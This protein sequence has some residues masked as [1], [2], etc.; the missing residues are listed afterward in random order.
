MRLGLTI[1]TL[2]HAIVLAWCVLSFSARRL[3]AV[4]TESLPVDIVSTSEF[5]KM[6]AGVK[7]APKAETPKQL[8]EKVAE[9]KPAP[10]AVAKVTEKQEIKSAASEPAPP[11]VEQPPKPEVKPQKTPDEIA[12]A[13][14]KELVKQPPPKKQPPKFDLSKVENKLALVDKREQRRQ[15]ATGAT[16]NDA[17]SLGT[18]KGNAPSLS[19]SELDALRARLKE[20]WGVPV[21][22]REARDL[23]VEVQFE[24][25]P[26]GSL[27]G[28]PKVV[29]RLSHPAFQVAAEYAVRAVIKGAPYTFLSPAKYDVWKDLVVSFD[30]QQMFGG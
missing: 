21:G 17:P 27:K 5:S 22:V 4:P 2:L 11:K 26:D 15:A 23:L 8:V 13:L 28:E 25:N 3:D 9:E 12:E 19:Q 16:L 30:P 1:S 24:L 7:T 14:K 20:N 18:A 10:E 6:T 29:N